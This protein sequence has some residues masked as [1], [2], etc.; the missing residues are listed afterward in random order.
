LNGAEKK[1]I[2]LAGPTASGKTDLAL[3]LA[4]QLPLRLIS[5]DSMQVYRGM[6]IGTSKPPK[7]ERDKFA[8][9]DIVDPGDG[10]S[11]G[12]F[13]SLARAACQDAWGQGL[14]PCVVGG[15]GLYIS[16]LVNGIAEVP[17]IDSGIRRKVEG[18]AH[19][20]RIREL[21]RLDPE[22]GAKTELKNPRRVS[23]ALEVVLA[24]GKGLAAWQREAQQDGIAAG[25][26]LGICLN[27][28]A[29]LLREK[30][31]K[32]NEIAFAAGWPDE[33][34]ALARRHGAD[35]IRSTGAIGYAELLDLG[36]AEAKP[37]IE[38]KTL[39]YAR[40]QRSWFRREKWLQWETETLNIEKLAE[41]FI[42][43]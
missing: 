11:A 43:E 26:R 31:K 12:R 35:A 1:L 21:L 17:E 39:Q 10:F 27:P 28:D 4:A 18:L 2:L 22:T 9:I 8:L 7:A 5:A 20:E 3:K 41:N 15:S 42:R 36:P 24:T 25:R 16:A 23:R 6:D 19:E 34:H 29:A 14:I 33:A 37:L 13:S 38:L 32:R 40:R 30:I